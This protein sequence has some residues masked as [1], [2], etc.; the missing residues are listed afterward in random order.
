MYTVI[1]ALDGSA[2]GERAL[3]FGE[4]LARTLGAPLELVHVL[5]EPIAFDLVPSLV[6]PDRPAAE[7]YVAGVAAGLAGDVPVTSDVLRGNATDELLGLTAQRPDALCVLSTHGR[8]GLGRTMLGSVADKVLRGSTVPVALVREP[9]CVRADRLKN[10]LVLLDGSRLAEEALPLALE[11][12]ERVDA[13]LSLVRIVEPVWQT[14]VPPYP[15]EPGT[16]LTAEQAA[17]IEGHLLAEARLYLSQIAALV[18]ERRIRVTWEVRCGRPVEEI[19]RLAATSATDVIV[20]STHGRGG[21]RR[22]ALGSVLD[23]LVH[24]C[25]VPILAIPPNAAREARAAEERL[26]T[27]TP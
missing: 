8:S 7:R 5:E 15:A 11:I 19:T 3:G 10:L 26:L 22:W 4:R 17:E 27:A 6:M 21:F 16:F 25:P 9:V 2:F 24:Y 18:Q 20:L 12:A 14:A 13:T 1:V 23:E